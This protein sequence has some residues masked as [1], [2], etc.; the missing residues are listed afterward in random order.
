MVPLFKRNSNAS[1]ANGGGTATPPPL[2]LHP[3]LWGQATW[4]QCGKGFAVVTEGIVAS[5]VCCGIMRLNDA[6][7]CSTC[8]RVPSRGRRNVGAK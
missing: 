6:F 3:R 1:I 5:P 8:E 2:E 4:N 7:K